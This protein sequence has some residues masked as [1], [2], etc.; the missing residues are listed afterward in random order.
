LITPIII[1]PSVDYEIEY[2]DSEW[3]HTLLLIAAMSLL[4]VFLGGICLYYHRTTDGNPN[5]DYTR[6]IMGDL[7][8]DLAALDRL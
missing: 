2:D 4:S 1:I 7:D 6:P 5:G 8:F 3:D